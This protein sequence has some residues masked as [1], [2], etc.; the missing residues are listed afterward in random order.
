VSATFFEAVYQIRNF[1][2]S[3]VIRLSIL[4]V[5]GNIVLGLIYR[6]TL[7]TVLRV[8]EHFTLCCPA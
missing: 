7:Q 1:G 8:N 2:S 5:V 6:D 4:G 3:R